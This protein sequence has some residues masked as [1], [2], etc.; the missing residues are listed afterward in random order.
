MSDNQLRPWEM[1]MLALVLLGVL[2]LV[3]RAMKQDGWSLSVNKEGYG[4]SIRMTDVTGDQW[5]QS[6][7]R[8]EGLGGNEPPVFW[9]AG[10]MSE[11]ADAQQSGVVSEQLDN[12][13]AFDGSMANVPAALVAVEGYGNKAGYVQRNSLASHLNAY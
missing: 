11:I 3:W 12:G 13:A 4:N 9:N 6:G 5:L 1:Q 8:R 10:R 7:N 2:Y